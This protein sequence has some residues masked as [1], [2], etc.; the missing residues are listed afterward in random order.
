MCQVSAVT[1]NQYCKKKKT[2]K[3]RTWVI[4][5]ISKI[6]GV[7]ISIPSRKSIEVTSHLD[8]LDQRWNW[9]FSP[10]LGV[11]LGRRA[12]WRKKTNKLTHTACCSGVNVTSSNLKLQPIKKKTWRLLIKETRQ[13]NLSPPCFYEVTGVAI[14]WVPGELCQQRSLTRTLQFVSHAMCV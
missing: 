4:V 7:K 10:A 1:K 3:S 14:L 2:P 6:R 9:G 13:L 12:K 8:L 5:K 11:T